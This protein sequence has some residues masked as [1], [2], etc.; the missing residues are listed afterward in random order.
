[1]K[2]YHKNAQIETIP[3]VKINQNNLDEI[4]NFVAQYIKEPVSLEESRLEFERSLHKK[5]DVILVRNREDKSL[6]GVVSVG[7]TPVEYNGE[8]VWVFFGGNLIF[9]PEY[10]GYNIIERTGAR[11]FLWLRMMHPTRK[12]Y[13]AYGALSYKSFSMVSRN[14]E[15]YWPH[16]SI[17]TPPM[18][19]F[20]ISHLG[21]L[22]YG[23]DWDD[24]HKIGKS[25]ALCTLK[26]SVIEIPKNKHNNSSVQFFL[27]KNP[28]YKAGDCL[29]CL[30]PLDVKNWFSLV[31]SV[32]RYS[33]RLKK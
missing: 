32:T 9:A 27:N 4:W 28:G 33:L 30:V 6:V 14:F 18:E 23:S 5:T 17:E 19:S 10:R 20:L 1:M 13:V 12:I 7:I 11:Y 15:R 8:T 22:Y 25:S 2:F 21:K 16:P 29:L 26:E 24:T 31:R 3:A